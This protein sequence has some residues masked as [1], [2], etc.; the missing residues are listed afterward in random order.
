[1]STDLE[2]L[3]NLGMSGKMFLSSFVW[4]KSGKL[5]KAIQ[6]SEKVKEV[7]G[8]VFCRTKKKKLVDKKKLQEFSI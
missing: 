6:N 8:V 3:E 7:F 2:I 5:V 4:E 1:V